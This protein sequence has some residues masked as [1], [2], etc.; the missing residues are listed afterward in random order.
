V[1][2]FIREPDGRFVPLK[3][4]VPDIAPDT[5][6]LASRPIPV[7]VNEQGV[8]LGNYEDKRHRTRVF[9]LSEDGGV[10]SFVSYGSTYYWGLNSQGQAVGDSFG[11]PSTRHGILRDEKEKVTL[12]DWPKTSLTQAKAINDKGVIVGVYLDPAPNSGPHR[13][14]IRDT[15]GNLTAFDFP[16]A[17]QTLVTGINNA[18][19][20]IGHCYGHDGMFGFVAVPK[21]KP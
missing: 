8:I 4:D 15:K 1:F 19:E 12:I 7:A 3:L 6:P 5:G 10:R 20:I 11:L 21:S 14:F 9:L 16:G 18:G 13:S 2:G 17:P